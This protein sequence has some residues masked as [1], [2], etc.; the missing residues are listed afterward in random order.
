MVETMKKAVFSLFIFTILVKLTGLLRELSLSYAYGASNISDA[1][2][3]SMTIPSVVF[4]FVGIAISTSFIPLFMKINKD[5]KDQYTT[6]K[7]SNNLI[8][9]ALILSAIVYFLSFI[10]T[11][12]LIRVFASGFSNDVMN[13]AITFTRITL[14]SIFL[15]S[16]NFVFNGYIQSNNNYNY[17]SFVNIPVNIIATVFILVSSFSDIRLLAWGTVISIL[18]QLILLVSKAKKYGYKYKFEVDIKN[19]Y[20][21]Q[22]LRLAVPLILGIS[23]NQINVLVDRTI[24]STIVEG[25]ISALNYANKL[26]M[27]VYGTLVIAITTVVFPKISKLAAENNIADLKNETVKALN[28]V[29]LFVMPAAIGAMIFSNQIVEMLFL[30][31]EFGLEAVNL[32]SGALL[33]YSLGMIFVGIREIIT[34]CFYAVNDSKTPTKNAII[35]VIVNITL[36]IVLSR[37]W[38]LNGLALATSISAISSALLLAKDFKRKFKSSIFKGSKVEYTKIFLSSIIMGLISKLVFQYISNVIGSNL[39]LIISIF[40]GIIVYF[41]CTL[42]MKVNEIH[43]LKREIFSKIMRIISKKE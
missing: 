6:N 34:R 22:T 1:Y 39:S 40:I 35:A 26:N 30:R 4:S 2:I 14:I 10:F 41:A 36:N 9:F 42:V 15:S 31:G 43:E 38:G 18:F 25:G 29:M 19:E 37:F 11:E 3:I 17:T 12:Q 16:I 13:I 8:N 33:F 23:V 28:L 27:F 21:M 20:L 32:T 24:A 5:G 7:Y